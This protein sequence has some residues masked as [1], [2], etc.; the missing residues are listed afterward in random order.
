MTRSFQL[1]NSVKKIFQSKLIQK[2]EWKMKC[3]PV[4]WMMLY[5]KLMMMLVVPVQVSKVSKEVQHP[6]LL[7]AKKVQRKRLMVK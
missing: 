6:S 4:K 3:L 5:Q 2:K 7:S 1:I